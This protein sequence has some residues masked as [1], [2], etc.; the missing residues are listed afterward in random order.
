MLALQLT[1]TTMREILAVPDLTRDVAR[2]FSRK[3][4]LESPPISKEME[5]RC[6]DTPV[7]HAHGG[8]RDAP[9]LHARGDEFDLPTFHIEKVSTA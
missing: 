4:G 5:R 7:L 2:E 1:T 9:V 3:F 6:S 8:V